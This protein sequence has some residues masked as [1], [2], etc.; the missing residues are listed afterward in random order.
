[1]SVERNATGAWAPLL[2]RPFR[3]LWIA[4]IA[5]NLSMWMQNIGAAW[6]MTELRPDSP[7]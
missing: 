2:H 6:M 1:M 7:L 5:V 4:A 3:A